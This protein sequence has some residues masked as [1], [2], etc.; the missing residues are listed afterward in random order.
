MPLFL[1]TIGSAGYRDQW[2]KKVW[3]VQVNRMLEGGGSCWRAE[4]ILGG[5]VLQKRV[6]RMDGDFKNLNLSGQELKNSPKIRVQF[7]L[8]WSCYFTSTI[9]GCWWSWCKRIATWKKFGNLLK[10]NSSVVE[11]WPKSDHALLPWRA[12]SLRKDGWQYVAIIAA[13]LWPKNGTTEPFSS[14]YGVIISFSTLQPWSPF[15]ESPGNFSG[16]KAN[17]EIKSSWKVP[18]FLAH[19]FKPINFASI[20]DSFNIV[21]FQNHW[22]SALECKHGKQKTTFRAR[23]VV[24]TFGKRSS[25]VKQ[26]KNV[27]DINNNIN[28]GRLLGKFICSSLPARLIEEFP[29]RKVHLQPAAWLTGKFPSKRTSRHYRPLWVWA[30]GEVQPFSWPVA[31]RKVSDK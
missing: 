26:R 24:A 4:L 31:G 9:K 13:E 23:K 7:C 2:N 29:A 28:V 18:Q 3:C 8:K 15:L 22:K 10:F 27:N 12:T 6:F 21:S 25:E 14:Y 16:A 17:F 11:K 30:K 20:I 19:K 1:K 5:R